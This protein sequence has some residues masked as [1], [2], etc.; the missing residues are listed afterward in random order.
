MQWNA[1]IDTTVWKFEK[2]HLIF[3]CICFRIIVSS[4]EQLWYNTTIETEIGYK[5]TRLYD[6]I[7]SSMVSEMVWAIFILVAS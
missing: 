7:I 2:T 6:M 3:I 1:W 4:C 5:Y